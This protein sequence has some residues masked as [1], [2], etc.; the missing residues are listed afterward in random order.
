MNLIP[1]WMRRRGVPAPASTVP[2]LQIRD[3]MGIIMIDGRL[4]LFDANDPNVDNGE[5]AVA[6]FNKSPEIA[7]VWK[8]KARPACGP[9]SPRYGR[10]PYHSGRNAP[11]VKEYR[12]VYILGRLIAGGQL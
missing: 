1:H 12:Q 5:L 6:V 10:T 9:R 2:P 8:D 4:C 7:P 3:G 11:D